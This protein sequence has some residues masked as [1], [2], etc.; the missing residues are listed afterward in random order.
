VNN[1][2]TTRFPFARVAFASLLVGM[3]FV[4]F[5]LFGN[6]TET[7]IFGHSAFNWMLTLWKS[8][9][10]FGGNIY[11]LGWIMPLVTLLLIYRRR[12]DMARV[13]RAVCWPGL[14]IVMLA[15]FLHWA[16][17]RAQQTR[18]SLMA[19]ILLLWAIPF[20]LYGWPLARQLIF[21]LGL[22]IFCVPL[23]FLDAFTFPM[24]VLS[25][26]GAEL[27][28]AGL[29]LVV[30]RAG[31]VIRLVDPAITLNGADPAS[32]LG[33]LLTL[34]AAALVI[35]AWRPDGWLLRIL[36]PAVVV[37]FMMIAGSLRLLL[38]ILLAKWISVP[39]AST[40]HDLGGLP[41]MLGLPLLALLLLRH[42]LIRLSWFAN[43]T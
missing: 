3:L 9:R 14:L 31:S 30:E 5:H 38:G 16:G 13:A 32:G 10:I 37:P 19:L 6:T 39:A 40:F 11:F 28:S 42:R 24:R 34:V 21:P 33:T 36:L 4:Q 15:I 1:K 29:G 17:A 43:H 2:A 7:N 23:N 20:F 25:A 27:L 26:A 12:G 8:G 41:F 35:G 18:L 22:L